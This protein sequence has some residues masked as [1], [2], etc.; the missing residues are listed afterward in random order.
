MQNSFG[1][2]PTR[3]RSNTDA[4]ENEKGKGRGK[5]RKGS[6]ASALLDFEDDLEV[7]DDEE[8]LGKNWLGE[9]IGPLIGDTM[10]VEFEVGLIEP[11]L[12][13]SVYPSTSSSTSASTSYPSNSHSNSN[14]NWYQ[15]SD[16][17]EQDDATYGNER[18]RRGL[19]PS[20]SN[21]MP[22]LSVVALSPRDYSLGSAHQALVARHLVAGEPAP[23]PLNNLSVGGPD[24]SDTRIDEDH[25][26]LSNGD[27][28]YVYSYNSD[29]RHRQSMISLGA[30]S[31]SHSH[32]YS[33]DLGFNLPMPVVP[34]DAPQSSDMSIIT[35][36]SQTSSSLIGSLN[37]VGGAYQS[38]YASSASLKVYGVDDSL[39]SSTS[40]G[41]QHHHQSPHDHR[42]HPHHPRT[43]SLG[44]DQDSNPNSGT[45]STLMTPAQSLQWSLQGRES[46]NTFRQWKGDN[47]GFDADGYDRDTLGGL[48]GLSRRSRP[49]QRTPSPI[50]HSSSNFT[51]QSIPS[52]PHRDARAKTKSLVDHIRQSTF[53]PTKRTSANEL[54]NAEV[55]MNRVEEPTK[56]TGSGPSN[57]YHPYR[58]DSA[59]SHRSHTSTNSSTSSCPS[60]VLLTPTS[61]CTTNTSVPSMNLA[62]ML[63]PTAIHSQ[64]SQATQL[65]QLPLTLR[66]KRQASDVDITSYAENVNV[67]VGGVAGMGISPY[68][69]PAP[70]ASLVDSNLGWYGTVLGR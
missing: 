19:G 40:G 11:L 24:D 66:Y 43:I 3:K 54:L 18:G 39:M 59:S 48:G 36:G 9:D 15:D 38:A 26:V 25:N 22:F 31:S 44:S 47:N 14:S 42:Q 21:M 46:S 52:S 30:H 61:T 7:D 64:H 57:R 63:P 12:D 34:S 6:K 27:S 51:T 56:N 68:S 49:Q 8:G 53:H 65:P 10:L 2:R 55:G 32:L 70:M 33:Q 67:N 29:N 5:K 69:V 37:F 23:K 17:S 35:S 4:K 13:P 62:T 58:T 50:S 1:E 60:P 28:M 41:H 45:T 16:G 20:E